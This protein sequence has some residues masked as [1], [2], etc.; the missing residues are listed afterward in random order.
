MCLYSKIDILVKRNLKPYPDP[1]LLV[2]LVS[3]QCWT[4]VC[5]SV[6]SYQCA[7]LNNEH[8]VLGLTRGNYLRV[9]SVIAISIKLFYC[10]LYTVDICW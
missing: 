10:R 2:L 7:G 4:L 5:I 8:I 1:Q 3:Y 6:T 9:L